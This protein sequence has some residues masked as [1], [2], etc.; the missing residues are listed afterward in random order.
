MQA[1]D[2]FCV[3]IATGMKR[4][5]CLII[6]YLVL[7]V[8]ITLIR[9]RLNTTRLLST[10]TFLFT[11]TN[12]RRV[13]IVAFFIPLANAFTNNPTLARELACDQIQAQPAVS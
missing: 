5:S 12:E 9:D 1:N 2:C 11:A 6:S 4:S 13:C 10:R 7:D 8:V 3:Q